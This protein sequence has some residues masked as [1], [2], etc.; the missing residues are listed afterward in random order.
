MKSHLLFFAA[1]VGI[2]L[3][4]TDDVLARVPSASLYPLQ[5]WAKN[6]G[7]QLT[8]NHPLHRYNPVTIK[9]CPGIDLNLESAWDITTGSKEIIVAILD[10]GFDFLHSNVSSNILRH[11]GETGLDRHGLEKESN[12][13]DDDGNGYAD[14]VMGF[15]FADRNG[16]PNSCLWDVDRYGKGQITCGY[17]HGNTALGI[18]GANPSR[19]FGIAGINWEISMMLLRKSNQQGLGSPK[20]DDP[21]N[22]AEAIKYAVENGAKIINWSGF[23]DSVSPSDKQG[24]M[25]AFELAKAKGV[26]IVVGAGNAGLNIDVEPKKLPFPVS[27][28]FDNVVY[29]ANV[30]ACGELIDYTNHPKWTGGSNWGMR[31][32]LAAPAQDGLTTGT[33]ENGIDT[34]MLGGGTSDAA[35]MVTGVAAL[36]LSVNPKLDYRQL[37]EILC[38]TAKKLPSL[39]AKT[40]CGGIPDAAAAVRM[41]QKMK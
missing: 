39:T 22:T 18:I 29:I 31:T 41:A 28:D 4:W 27:L 2:W 19:Q 1:L 33:R 20:K 13:I 32:F 30:G 7:G 11:P 14:D 38:K 16:N 40:S 34:F 6:H 17:W 10:D 35:P 24:L 37:K 5:F 21:K 26:L 8:V 25:D 3:G 15:N 36:M 12:G 9:T 23:Y